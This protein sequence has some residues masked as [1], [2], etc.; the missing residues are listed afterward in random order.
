[1]GMKRGCGHT[2]KQGV[3]PP[4]WKNKEEGQHRGSAGGQLVTAGILFV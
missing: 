2:F 1:M 3:R 4:I